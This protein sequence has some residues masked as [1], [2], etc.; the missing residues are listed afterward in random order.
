MLGLQERVER[1]SMPPGEPFFE[2][3]EPRHLLSAI[4]QFDHV[5]IVVEE[6]HSYDEIIGAAD[7]PYINGL[8]ANG[9]L[10]TQS[11]AISHPSQPNYLALFSGSTQGV[12]TDGVLPKFHGPDLYSH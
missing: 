10:F 1:T 5:V 9:A 3:L 8:A 6:N 4:P 12:T 11:F 2:P 7:L